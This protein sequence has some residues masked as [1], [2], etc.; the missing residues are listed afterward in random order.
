M[1]ERYKKKL[2]PKLNIKF[3]DNC[4]QFPKFRCE[5]SGVS[6]SNQ[7]FAIPFRHWTSLMVKLINKK[8]MCLLK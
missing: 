1:R 3:I 8:H 6:D 2:N 4:K 7:R 5:Y